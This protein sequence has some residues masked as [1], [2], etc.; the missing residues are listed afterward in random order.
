VKGKI[1]LKK[2]KIKVRRKANRSKLTRAKFFEA[3]ADHIEDENVTKKTVKMIFDNLNEFIIEKL[4]D[5]EKIPLGPLGMIVLR[6]RAA[7]IGRNPQ[8]GE[9]IKI[10]PKRSVKI[11]VSSMIRRAFVKAKKRAA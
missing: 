6:D 5:L 10:G 3:L 7:R 11:R 8:T 9:K 2:K 1:M 4:G